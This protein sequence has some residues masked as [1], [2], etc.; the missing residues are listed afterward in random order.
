MKNPLPILGPRAAAPK[1]SVVRFSPE[2][3]SP[4]KAMTCLTVWR[5]VM[6]LRTTSTPCCLTSV[7]YSPSDLLIAFLAVPIPTLVGMRRAALLFADLFQARYTFSA[8]SKFLSTLSP[9]DVTASAHVKA[10][11]A[12]ASV[13]SSGWSSVS[14]AMALRTFSSYQPTALALPF[15]AERA[16]RSVMRTR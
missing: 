10:K 15:R 5:S 13:S 6:N 4:V 1:T 11:R 16:S 8:S 2:T 12:S 3:F 9:F 14:A 7:L